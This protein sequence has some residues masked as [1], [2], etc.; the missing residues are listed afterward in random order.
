M[1]TKYHSQ[2]LPNLLLDC[3]F[4]LFLKS[5]FSDLTQCP[6][7]IVRVRRKYYIR[8]LLIKLPQL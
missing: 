2:I 6:S 3:K 1:A 7:N 8:K 5:N 4:A